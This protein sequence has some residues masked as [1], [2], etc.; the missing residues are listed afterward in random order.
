MLTKYYFTFDKKLNKFDKIKNWLS[1]QNISLEE[2]FDLS[3]NTWIKAG[4]VCKIFVT[5]KSFDEV[6][7]LVDYLNYNSFKFKVFGSMSNILIRDG[8]IETIIINLRKLSLIK[9]EKNNEKGF[10]TLTVETGVPMSKFSFFLFSK[11]IPGY[12]GLYGIPGSLGGGLYMNA[13][14]YG[15]SITE[16]LEKIFC[17]DEHGKEIEFLKNEL[18]YSYR[19]SFL[20][21]KNYIILK[22][23][24]KFIFKSEVE[25]K[26]I[27]KNMKRYKRHRLIFQEKKYPNL[28]T[29]FA[30]EKGIYHD[31]SKLSLRFRFY[32]LFI[33]I[34]EKILLKIYYKF[35]Q[36]SLNKKISNFRKHI[37]NLYCRHLNLNRDYFSDH[38]L[39]CLVN[40]NNKRS[41]LL[42]EN[43]KKFNNNTSNLLTL[44]VE[45]FDNLD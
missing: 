39:N 11:N 32:S 15:S 5:P 34:A 30:S 21:N 8:I 38:T 26:L 6:K 43:V 35:D 4:G 17:L 3:K 7:N 14:S 44:E 45:L 19:K 25:S 40:R 20:Q 29:L 24:Y 16:N 22:A 18:N 28:G 37:V 31:L 23:V 10:S 12:E 36:K 41:D 9:L 13:S 2:N 1:D 42:I 33:L 27:L